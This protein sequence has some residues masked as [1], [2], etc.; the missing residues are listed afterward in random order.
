MPVSKDNRTLAIL[1][2]AAAG[3]YGVMAAIAY[4][5]EQLTGLVRAAESRKSPLIIQ[6]FPSTLKQ[7]PLLAHAAA[8]AV[9]TATVPLSLHIDHAQDVEH[10][11]EIIA[12]LP[13][14][15]VMVDMSHYD[16]AEN[17]E[18]TRILTKECQDKGIAVEAESGRINGGEDGIADTGDLEALFTSPEDVDNFIAAGVDILA[19]SIGN[20]HGDYGPAGPKEG[21]LHYDRLEAIDKQINKRVLVA[22]HGTNDFPPEV[23]QRCIRSG[24]VKLNVNKLL[25]EPGNEVLRKNA[26]STPLAKLIDMQMD[27]IQ[28][29]TERWMDICGSSGKGVKAP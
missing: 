28:E 15:S 24:A 1:N 18:K 25:L 12:T 19:P 14:D 10:I 3:N 23:M 27:V 4:N 7:L 2:A 17:L 9:K 5:V 11:R 8:H 26:P 29:A 16:E 13:V 6:L 22:L 21:Q 20:V